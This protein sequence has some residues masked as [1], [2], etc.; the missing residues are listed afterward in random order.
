MK[1][2]KLIIGI[3]NIVAALALIVTAIVGFFNDNKSIFGLILMI[4]AGLLII[5]GAVVSYLFNTNIGSMALLSGS[6]VG[7]VAFRMSVNV[8]TNF[9]MIVW[10]IGVLIAL[11]STII[12][13]VGFD[14]KEFK[15]IWDKINLPITFITCVLVVFMIVLMVSLFK[16]NAV[17]TP[18]MLI[19]TIIL[20]IASK[21]LSMVFKFK[22]SSL[23]ML[24]VPLLVIMGM[25][26]SEIGQ[27]DSNAVITLVIYILSFVVLLGE[28]GS[29]KE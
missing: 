9:Q 5:G 21:V 1:K 3:I 22:F 29:L 23:L 16:T 25:I 19:S 12:N 15:N 10:F 2:D 7:I 27:N 14:K 28:I 24:L 26:P 4:C 11:V 18:I 8:L 17:V 20:M 6:V 13:Y